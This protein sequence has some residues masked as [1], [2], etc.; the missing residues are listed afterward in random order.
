MFLWKRVEQPLQVVRK[1]V[2]A[3]L[4]MC[5]WSDVSSVSDSEEQ[6]QNL[7]REEREVAA[8]ELSVAFGWDLVPPTVLRDG[9]AGEGSVQRFVDADFGEH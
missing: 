6:L 4:E 2:A 1:Q 9:P 5:D 7:L 3:S 8:Y